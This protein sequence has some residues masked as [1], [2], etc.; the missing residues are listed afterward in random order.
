M[1]FPDIVPELKLRMPELRGRLLGV[2]REGV[3]TKRARIEKL[4]DQ[5]RLQAD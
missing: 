1:S 5:Q 2:L 3:V 4:A